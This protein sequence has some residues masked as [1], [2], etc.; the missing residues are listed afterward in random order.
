MAYSSY[1]KNGHTKSERARQKF[2]GKE[3]GGFKI[4]IV[5]QSIVGEIAT[6]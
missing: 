1:A 6:Q 3:A 4:A 5:L 2:C